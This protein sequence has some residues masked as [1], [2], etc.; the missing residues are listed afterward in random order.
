MLSND[1]FGI[2]LA[3]TS[4]AIWGGGDFSGGFASRRSSPFQV[5]ALSAL[6]GIGALAV[7]AVLAGERL[8][9]PGSAL[10]AGLAGLTGALGLA[11]LYRA[12]SFGQAASVAP[13]AAVIGAALP[14]GFSILTA[15]L[16]GASRLAGFGLALVGIWLVSQG[17]VQDQAASP[18][19]Y[20]RQAKVWLACL[21]GLSF[22]AFFILIGQVEPDRVFTS[23]I[24]SRSATFV[25]AVGLLRASRQG[26]IS[27]AA[28]PVA[29]LA[30]ILDAG[31]NVFFLLA[32]QFTHLEVAAVLSSL[33]PASTVLLSYFIFKE[34]ISPRQWLGVAVCLAAIGL[35]TV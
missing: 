31:G 29:F 2:L 4:A 12:L 24:I 26:M 34:T 22:G 9:S 14:V 16:P 27:P 23:L 10:W 19:A 5:L 17:T 21:A 30:G 35:I 3:L 18:L 25:V 28:N 20:F 32:R 15:G 11:C 8:P 33:Y 13:T 1:L 7:F 6:S